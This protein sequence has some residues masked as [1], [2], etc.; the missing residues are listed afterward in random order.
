MMDSGVVSTMCRAVRRC[1]G[2]WDAP[3][4]SFRTRH[5]GCDDVAD[6]DADDNIFA[7]LFGAKSSRVVL[8][9]GLGVRLVPNDGF[10][11]SPST[12]RASKMKANP[13]ARMRGP[14][15]IFRARMQP[16]VLSRFI[17]ACRRHRVTV[18]SRRCR[19]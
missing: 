13:R 7:L 19:S 16:S 4:E 10:M 17:I 3:A 12:C 8:E 9:R 18:T 6:D 2:I 14:R 5:R 15:Y 11:N 1:L